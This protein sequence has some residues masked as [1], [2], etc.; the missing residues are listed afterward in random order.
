MKKKIIILIALVLV[1]CGVVLYPFVVKR[2]F[3]SVIDVDIAKVN[4]I[5]MSSGT[6]G[7][8]VEITDKDTIDEFLKSFKETRIR[9]NFYQGKRTGYA[10]SARLYIDDSEVASF[11]YGYEEIIIYRNHKGKRYVS[12]KN[13]NHEEI[14]KIELKYNLRK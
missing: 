13:I 14:N 8:I 11:S 7:K 2:E 1:I 12:N 3:Q 9:K 4:K 5:L 10:L 6:Y